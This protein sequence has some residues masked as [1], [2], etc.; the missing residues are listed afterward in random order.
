[1]ETTIMSSSPLGQ[2]LEKIAE[3]AP[4]SYLTFNKKKINL[5]AKMTIGRNPDCTI[6]VD[7]KL[8]S[9]VHATIQKIKDVYFVKDEDST[10]GTYLNGHRIAGGDNWTRLN[11]GDK[12]TI[13]AATLVFA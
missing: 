1:M 4:V 11:P 6:V 12:V 9:R 10:N 2:H 7:D 3:G 8:A 5:V 13:G